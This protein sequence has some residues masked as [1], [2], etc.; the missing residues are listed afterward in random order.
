MNRSAYR[1]KSHLS[2]DIAFNNISY[3]CLIKH[4]KIFTSL[5]IKWVCLFIFD[6]NC[7]EFNIGVNSKNLETFLR[8]SSQPKILKFYYLYFT[9]KVLLRLFI[10]IKIC[11]SIWIWLIISQSST[12]SF[13]LIGA[14]TLFPIPK[15]HHAL[16]PI[17]YG[18]KTNINW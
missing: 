15:L 1:L 17:F 5:L 6:Y 13:L 11:V 18:T 9:N 16:N 12:N 2:H 3:T 10:L 14:I 8:H 7:P 4:L